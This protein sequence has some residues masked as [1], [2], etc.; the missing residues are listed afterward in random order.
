M[1]TLIAQAMVFETY[2][3]RLSIAQLHQVTGLAVKTI[4]NQ[5]SAKT[6]PIKT[7]VDGGQRWAD[8]RDVAAHFDALREKAA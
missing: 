1:T 2:G 7:Y 3:P 8:F 4:Y 5:V 6:F